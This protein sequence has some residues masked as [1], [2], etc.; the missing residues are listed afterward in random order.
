MA[1]R[2]GHNIAHIAASISN[3][4]AAA[5]VIGSVGQTRRQPCAICREQD[6][7]CHPAAALLLD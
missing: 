3:A 4:G 2:A 5:F 7:V 1:R 6:A